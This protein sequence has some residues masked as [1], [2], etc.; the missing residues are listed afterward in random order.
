MLADWLTVQEAIGMG[1]ESLKQLR[2]IVELT[3]K[4]E[5]IEGT[6]GKNWITRFVARHNLFRSPRSIK[7]SRSGIRSGG[8]RRGK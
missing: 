5:G 8:W 7:S 2:G 1:V 3:L 6:V 4:R